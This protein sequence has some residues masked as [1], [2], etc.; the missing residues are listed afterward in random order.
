MGC[1]LGLS[2]HQRHRQSVGVQKPLG[3]AVGFLGV[4]WALSVEETLSI[5][6]VDTAILVGLGDQRLQQL[7]RP[8]KL[9]RSNLL[10]RPREADLSHVGREQKC[11]LSGCA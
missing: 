7:A 5:V 1:L 6:K 8:S 3:L 11:S 4:L 2:Q 9:A 10:N